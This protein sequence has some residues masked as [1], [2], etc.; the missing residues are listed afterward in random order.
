MYET[1]KDVI[2]KISSCKP[3][4][5]NITIEDY[6]KD[7]EFNIDNYAQTCKKYND[8]SLFLEINATDKNNKITTY[9]IPLN[10]NDNCAK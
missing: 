3:N 8:E 5:S 9:K 7:V 6:L 10:L 2:K 4:S 1:N